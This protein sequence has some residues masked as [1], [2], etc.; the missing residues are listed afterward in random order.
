MCVGQTF[1]TF[2]SPFSKYNNICSWVSRAQS[3]LIKR[4][5]RV[6]KRANLLHRGSLYVY[7]Y[8]VHYSF[9][10][11]LEYV[12]TSKA[13]KLMLRLKSVRRKL[14]KFGDRAAAVMIVQSEWIVVQIGKVV[15]V[16]VEQSGARACTQHLYH[17]FHG[18]RLRARLSFC[19]FPT[20]IRPIHCRFTTVILL[21]G[22]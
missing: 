21:A 20:I 22:K 14:R 16:V 19:Q 15:A 2:F 6:G 4:L 5:F 9:P 17:L 7:T 11:L 12:R 18:S 3:W 13:L 8:M 1:S 10:I